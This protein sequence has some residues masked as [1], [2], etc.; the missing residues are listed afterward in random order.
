MTGSVFGR[1]QIGLEG[2]NK[3]GPRFKAVGLEGCR[4]VYFAFNCP[5][6]RGTRTEQLWGI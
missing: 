6:I 2:Y 3:V 4:G 1:Q 5:L